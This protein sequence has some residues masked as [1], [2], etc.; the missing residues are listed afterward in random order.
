MTL[1]LE[2]EAASLYCRKVPNSVKRDGNDGPSIAKF[3]EGEK[4]LIMDLGGRDY[5]ND[6]IIDF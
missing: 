3:G 1:A 4:Y 2:P 6:G 5:Y